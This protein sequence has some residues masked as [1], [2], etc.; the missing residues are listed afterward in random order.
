MSVRITRIAFVYHRVTDI[1][2]ARDFYERVL[3][4][5][6]GLEY[7]GSPGKW[8]I[9]YDVDGFAFAITTVG[10]PQGSG[11]AVLTF[12]VADVEAA[13][14]F[15]RAAGAVFLEPLTEYPRCRSFIVTDPDGNQIGFHQLKPAEEIPKFVPSL[16]EKVEAYLH[17]PSGRTVAHHQRDGRGHIHLFSPT[18]FYVAT[19]SD[20]GLT[21]R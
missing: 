17:T 8:W 2:R 11:G 5:K 20:N 4:M 21:H 6:L 1:V 3:G 14:N 19:E 13:A 16:A 7:E 10:V 15:L 9:E 12:E 18:G